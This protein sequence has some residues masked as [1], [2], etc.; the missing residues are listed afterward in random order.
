MTPT[1]FSVSLFSSTSFCE[2]VKKVGLFMF[3]IPDFPLAPCLCE[4]AGLDFVTAWKYL[5]PR[6]RVSVDL[7]HFCMTVLLLESNYGCG[8]VVRCKFCLQKLSPAHTPA[9]QFFY[10]GGKSKSKVQCKRQY[11]ALRICAGATLR[12]E[13]GK[14]ECSFDSFHSLLPTVVQS[15]L[16]VFDGVSVFFCRWCRNHCRVCCFCSRRDSALAGSISAHS[17]WVL[18]VQFNPDNTHLASR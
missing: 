12:W 11:A 13:W 2:G 17:S 18:S 5:D 1:F 4:Q 9:W 6:T 10:G 15:L 16:F 14:S 3:K 7:H 8:P